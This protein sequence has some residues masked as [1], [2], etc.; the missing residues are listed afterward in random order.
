MARIHRIGVAVTVLVVAV[1]AGAC[2][3]SGDGLGGGEGASVG[4]AQRAAEV[5]GVT[6][7]STDLAAMQAGP[8]GAIP[9]MGPRI[10]KT[11]D[12]KLAV[13]SE[14]FKSAVHDAM[15]TAGRYSGFVVSTNLDT[16]GG[17]FGTLVLR[18]PADRFLQALAD[19]KDLGSVR[20]ESVSGQDVT[21]EFVDLQARLRNYRAQEVVLLR[22]M[23][24]AQSVSDTIRV[25][26]QLGQVQLEVER[27]KGRLRYLN[28]QTAMSTIMVR[29]AVAG[30][31]LAKAGTL[32]RAWQMA[33]RVAMSVVSGVIIGLGFIVPVALL[34]GIAFLIFRQL[35]PRLSS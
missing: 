25:Q 15:T 18:V 1:V 2:A 6:V 23:D 16:Q 33:M 8:A 7:G 22:L 26:Q 35:R 31:T 11:A 3:A 27:I 17:R 12:V 34:A 14:R 4:Q 21:Q 32:A 20:E 5:Q 30:V 24:R 29:F 28:D 13:P 10:I 19:L 9:P